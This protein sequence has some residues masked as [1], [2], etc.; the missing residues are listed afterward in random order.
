MS[1]GIWWI[2][3]FF[4]FP[5]F[6]ELKFIFSLSPLFHFFQSNQRLF[7][8]ALLGRGSWG[9]RDRWYRLQ[10]ESWEITHI[11]FSFVANLM[12]RFLLEVCSAMQ[13][14]RRTRKREASAEGSAINC[15]GLIQLQNMGA[16]TLWQLFY[17]SLVEFQTCPVHWDSF[18]LVK[19]CAV[20][21]LP[22]D[23][24]HWRGEKT[25]A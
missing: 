6:M 17:F 18:H 25:P 3:F 16:I 4:Q 15:R 8:L 1:L 2:F 21:K 13:A 24:W 23:S 14:Q 5:T 12:P 22:S 7:S 11:S 20:F 19:T 10:K 9:R